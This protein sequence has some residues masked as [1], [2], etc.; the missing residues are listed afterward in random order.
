MFNWMNLEDLCSAKEAR[1]RKITVM[2][3]HLSEGPEVVKLMDLGSG[4]VVGWGWRKGSQELWFYR[5]SF[6]LER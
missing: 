4:I 5:Y 1:H 2:G 3:F 6:H